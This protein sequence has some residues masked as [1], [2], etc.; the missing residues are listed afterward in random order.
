MVVVSHPLYPPDLAFA[1]S[2]PPPTP[3][4]NRDFKG[5]R[6]ADLTEV[7]RESLAALDSFSVADFRLFPAVGAALGSL[8]PVTG[9]VF[10]RWLKCQTCMDILNTF[11]ASIP[12]HL[13][14]VYLIIV[15]T[16]LDNS[17]DS[18]SCSHVAFIIIIIIITKIKS[19]FTCTIFTK[20]VSNHFVLRTVGP[21]I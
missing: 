2:T 16:A 10:W 1:T 3:G 19:L 21:G 15:P 18:L 9:G 12:G 6:F 7:Q 20:W 13:T 8:R 14:Y 5:R 11:F 17:W 4:L